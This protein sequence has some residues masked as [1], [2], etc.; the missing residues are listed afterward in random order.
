MNAMDLAHLAHQC[1][2]EV[3]YTTLAAIVRTE[4]NG[5]PWALGVNG[6]PRL[7]RQPRSREEAARWARWL[8]RHGYNVDIG[9]MQ[10]NSRHLGRFA[11][12][13]DQL[14]E[15]CTNL[16]AGSVVLREFY[17]RAQ[18]AYGADAKSVF[19][20]LSAYNTGSMTRGFENGYV[21]AVLR[22]AGMTG[23]AVGSL[24]PAPLDRSAPLQPAQPLSPATPEPSALLRDAMLAPTIV[25]Q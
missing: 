13:V 15:P 22:M 4:S 20:A 17:L 7:A 10:V 1:A 24:A 9:L 18:A 25:A 11:V 16:R 21:R 8:I 14:L 3:A 12:D 5:H 2:P 6:G 19:S 23:A